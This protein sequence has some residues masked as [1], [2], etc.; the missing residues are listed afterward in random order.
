FCCCLL[1][2]ASTPLPYT[3]LF[4]SGDDVVEPFDVPVQLSQGLAQVG[5]GLAEHDLQLGQQPGDRVAQVV[6]GVEQEPL[7]VL[8]GLVQR[9]HR[10]LLLPERL[11]QPGVEFQQVAGAVEV[12]LEPFALAGDGGDVPHQGGDVLGPC[13]DPA[14]LAVPAE[15]RHLHQ[16]PVAFLGQAGPAGPNVVP[17]QRDD[18]EVLRARH[19]SDRGS[20]RVHEVRRAAEGG[21]ERLPDELRPGAAG[22]L[23]AGVVDRHDLQIRR[24]HRARRRYGV[25]HRRVVELGPHRTFPPR[26]PYPKWP[27]RCE[28]GAKPLKGRT[29][30]AGPD[31]TSAREPWPARRRP[32]PPHAPAPPPAPPAP[33][34]AASAA[35]PPAPPAAPC[36]PAPSPGTSA[37]RRRTSDA[38]SAY[39]KGPARPPAR[40]RSRRGWPPPCCTARSCRA[41][42]P[43]RRPRPPR[44]GSAAGRCRGWRPSAASPPPP[45][46][47]ATGP[48][49]A[50]P[51]GS[52]RPAASPP[53]FRSCSPWSRARRPAAPSR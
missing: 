1:P 7:L 45:Y 35:A 19:P 34:T 10:P 39:G 42:A 6:G 13:D 16:R 18:V 49:A 28:N 38:G 52:G 23:Q 20:Q 3:T 25:E 50:V 21:Q 2:R 14:Q 17:D 41:A 8:D 30:Q 44:A 5:L 36:G 43:S 22:L 29:G 33:A 24:H 26:P 4:R 9:R 48:P 11:L 31:I 53:S 12:R 27:L 51:T 37:D 40:T 47:R 32:A 46:G 15:H